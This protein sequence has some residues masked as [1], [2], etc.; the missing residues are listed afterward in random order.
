LE[1]VGDPGRPQE[2]AATFRDAQ[3]QHR[4]GKR[5]RSLM[6]DAALPGNRKPLTTLTTRA[7]G[8]ELNTF[9]NTYNTSPKCKW[10]DGSLGISFM[11][12]TTPA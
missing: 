12:S 4:F 11:Q 2:T 5:I 9:S 1:A 3:W 7:A 8:T 10:T 6:T